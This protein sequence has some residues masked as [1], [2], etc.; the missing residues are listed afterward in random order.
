MNLLVFDF[1]E[2]P[3]STTTSCTA[4]FEATTPTSPPSAQNDSRPG[5]RAERGTG[6][7]RSP[8]SGRARGA[9]D[10]AP[11]VILWFN[12]ASA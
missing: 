6:D 12:G 2:S 8:T 5:E 10:Y 4:E 9:I 3:P 11:R 7:M 1:P